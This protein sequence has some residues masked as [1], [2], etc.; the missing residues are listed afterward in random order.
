W[1]AVAVGARS[2][3][4]RKARNPAPDGSAGDQHG[5][6]WATRRR[7]P[8]VL[9]L[10]GNRARNRTGED[11]DSPELRGAYPRK[12]YSANRRTGAEDGRA[13]RGGDVHRV[14]PDSAIHGELDAGLPADDDRARR[15]V[16]RRP[17]ARSDVC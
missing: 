5:R 4:S 12:R 14:E 8:S 10:R 15:T 3:D 2:V 13:D 6:H 17:W 9:T 16:R 1:I 7:A 11:E